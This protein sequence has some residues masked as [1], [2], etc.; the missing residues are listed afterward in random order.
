LVTDSNADSAV[1]SAITAIGVR[2]IQA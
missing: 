1:C 2:V